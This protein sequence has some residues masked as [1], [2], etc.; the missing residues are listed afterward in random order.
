MRNPYENLGVS[1]NATADEIKSA[2]LSTV[3]QIFVFDLGGNL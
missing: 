1:K 3:C 2:Y